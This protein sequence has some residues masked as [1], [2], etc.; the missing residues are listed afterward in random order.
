MGFS[1]ILMYIS[2]AAPNKRSLGAMN[3]VAQTMVSIQRTSCC[4]VVVCILAGQQHLWG[5]LYVC[6]A[7]RR[8]LVGLGVAVQLP[9][10]AWKR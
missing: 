7:S 9:R 10:I 6:S 8:V 5:K 2:S 4:R 3:G 1:T